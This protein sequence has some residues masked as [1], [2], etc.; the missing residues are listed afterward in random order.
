MKEP[1]VAEVIDNIERACRRAGREPSTVR[2]LAVTKQVPAEI[3]KRAIELGIRLIGENR[4]QE[5]RAKGGDG[6][7]EGAT[8]CLIGHLQSNKASM[9]AR[10]FDEAHT[11]DS[12][13]IATALSRFRQQYKGGSGP[14]PVLLEVNAGRDPAKYGVTLEGAYDLARKVL[15]MPNLVLQGLMTIAPGYGDQALARETFRR[16]R[17]LRDDL[18]RRGVPAENLRELS[19]GMSADYQTAV[20]EGSTMVRIGTALFG[21]RQ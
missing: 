1:N 11:V 6:S 7:Y 12:E 17:V 18:A 8:L 10:I 19:M 5:A 15:D 2:L 9:A 16:L 14:F 21:P 3:V 4:V 20:E 13:R